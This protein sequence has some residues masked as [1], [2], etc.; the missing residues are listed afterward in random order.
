[1]FYSGMS[2]KL[3]QSCLTFCNP[4][5]CSPLGSSAHG[6]LQARISVWVAIPSPRGSSH[7]GIEPGSPALQAGSLP[8]EPQG[9]PFTHVVTIK[10]TILG[11]VTYSRSLECIPHALLKLHTHWLDAPHFPFSPSCHIYPSMAGLFHL[12]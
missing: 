10:I 12:V 2:A 3:L 4:L 7:S 11:M 6:I 9:K 8:S 5:D 1:M